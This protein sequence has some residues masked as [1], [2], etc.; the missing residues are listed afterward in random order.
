[1]LILG[2]LCSLLALIG[3][4]NVFLNTL[5]FL[6]QRR[7][8]LAQYMSVGMTPE[9][10]R[11][12]FYIEVLV[13]AGRPL[14]ITIPLTVLAVGFMIRAS[15]LDAKEFLVKAP[16]VPAMIFFLVILGC[17][18]LAYYIGGRKLFRCNLADALRDESIS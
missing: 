12:I 4:A 8:E 7:W 13:I 11:Q 2:G 1:M 10:I 9:E 18:A 17:V 6:S 15:Y 16:I 14:L 5:G 3:I